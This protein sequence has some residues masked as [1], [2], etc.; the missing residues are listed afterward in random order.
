MSFI[1]AIV[2]K[3]P[4]TADHQVDPPTESVSLL[5]WDVPSKA[6][7]GDH[8]ARAHELLDALFDADERMTQGHFYTI[9]VH[10]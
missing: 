10:L 2:L 9:E 5:G 1:R 7:S 3:E 4:S 6:A 8:R